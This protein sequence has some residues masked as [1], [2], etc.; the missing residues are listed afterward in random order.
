M[1]RPNPAKHHTERTY[2]I[3]IIEDN[4]ADVRLFEVALESSGVKHTLHVVNDGEEA[5]DFVHRRN[6]HT[7]APRPDLIVMDLNIPRLSG[8][9]VL[10]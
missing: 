9:K 10:Q 1:P 3:L 8:D 2:R 7:H 4:P 6:A 5:L